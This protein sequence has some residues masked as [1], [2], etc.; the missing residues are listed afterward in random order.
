MVAM[1]AV[2]DE[3]LRKLIS[4]LLQKYVQH[5]KC[6]CLWFGDECTCGLEQLKKKL[7]IKIGSGHEI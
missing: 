6:C 3:E 4:V 7:D 1:D 5:P 2:V